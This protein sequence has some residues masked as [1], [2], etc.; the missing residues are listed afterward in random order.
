MI[1]PVYIQWEINPAQLPYQQWFSTTGWKEQFI[2]GKNAFNAASDTTSVGLIENRYSEPHKKSASHYLN[3]S[4]L[5]TGMDEHDVRLYIA[6]RSPDH[7]DTTGSMWL[8][9]DGSMAAMEQGSRFWLCEEEVLAVV[10][11][12]EDQ[13]NSVHHPLWIRSAGYWNDKADSIADFAAHSIK[14]YSF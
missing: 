14:H 7:W 9:D 2:E 5:W 12:T 13:M 8:P 1:L 10:T 4:Q 6:S 11:V 3:P